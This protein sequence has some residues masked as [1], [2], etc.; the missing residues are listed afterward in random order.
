LN[1][2]GGGIGC[3][4]VYEISENRNVQQCISTPLG[5]IR[6]IYGMKADVNPTVIFVLFSL[7]GCQK[8][9]PCATYIAIWN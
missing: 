9:A 2:D 3:V 4:D 6:F 7:I 1:G 5:L 8:L